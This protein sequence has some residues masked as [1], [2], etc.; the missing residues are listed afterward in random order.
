MLRRLG[1][2]VGHERLGRDGVASWALAV[3]AT[4]TPWGPSWHDVRFDVVLHQ[5][6]HPLG[7]VNSALSFREE[8]WRFICEHIPVSI[9][10]PLPLRSAAYW[11][12]WNNEAEKKAELTY[13]V[14]DVAGVLED[15]CARLGCAVDH[16]V[17]DRVPTDVNTRRRGRVFHLT[18]EALERLGF[19][20]VR[21]VW[22]RSRNAARRDPPAVGW[23]Q[24][25]SFDPALCDLMMA[26]A[27]EY[28]YRP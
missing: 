24:I 13:R 12:H 11:Y 19:P 20:P 28:G 3:D 16:S 1:L 2:D 4:S 23:D 21:Q 15:I 14:E 17:L 18:E 8:S 25:R 9:E 27:E 22:M 6:R 7:V 5:V 26:K 10:D